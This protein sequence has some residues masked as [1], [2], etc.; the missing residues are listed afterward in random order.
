[1][2]RLIALSLVFLWALRAPAEFPKP[3]FRET[4]TPY[5]A[6]E[7]TRLEYSQPRPLRAWVARIDVT[8]PDV[9]LVVTPRGKPAGGFQTCCATTLAFAQAEG[10]QLAI[11]G[12]PFEPLRYKPG[13]STNIIGVQKSR[14]D[15]IA[16][17]INIPRYA[18]MLVSPENRVALRNYPLTN[19]E[20]AKAR[21]AIGGYEILVENGKNR[22]DR[23]DPRG[24]THPRTALGTSEGGK[25]L[26]WLVADGRQAGRSEGLYLDELADW[27]ISLSISEL[28]NLDG[29]GS[30]TMVLQDPKTAA[31]KVLNSPVGLG[32]PGSLR[33]NGNNLGL[34]IYAEPNDL[35]AAQLRAIMPDLPANRTPLFLGALNRAMARAHIDNPARRAAFLAQLAHESGELKYMEELADGKVYEGRADLGNTQPAAGPRF[36]GR[37]PIQLTGR[38]NYRAAGAA[39]GLNLENDPTRVA[40]PEIGCQVAGWFWETHGLNELADAGKF[41]E[42]TQRINGGLNGIENREKYWERAKQTLKSAG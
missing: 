27:A 29:G 40:D 14:G 26:W 3:A 23:N 22:V 8:N 17:P 34:R 11:N 31:H 25:Y 15:L 1:M 5:P 35:K 13:E 36:K 19:S 20:L 38:A 42:I 37:G 28:L 12:S 33:Q 39:L 30:T 4:S 9:E 41:R 2:Q 18:A 16:P 24:P 6:V 10:V 32:V 7:L 21:H